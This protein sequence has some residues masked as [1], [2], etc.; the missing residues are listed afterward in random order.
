MHLVDCLRAVN[1]RRESIIRGDTT[2][3]SGVETY[4][5]NF[6]LLFVVF[7][8]WKTCIE[9]CPCANKLVNFTPARE[10]GTH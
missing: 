3:N 9:E 4:L 6:T 1:L 5:N 8:Y 7:Y 2:E 10:E